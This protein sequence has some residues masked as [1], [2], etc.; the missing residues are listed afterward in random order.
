MFC[1]RWDAMKYLI[2]EANYGGR[3]TDDRDR[4]LLRVYIN[5]FFCDAAITYDGAI[6]LILLRS[7]C[8]YFI[9]SLKFSTSRKFLE[10]L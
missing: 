2:A 10:S 5:Q 6:Y 7:I 3:V 9:L 1:Y 8:N 4:R